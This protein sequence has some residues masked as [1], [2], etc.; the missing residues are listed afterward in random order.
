MAVSFHTV[1]VTPLAQNAT[2]IAEGPGG[3]AVVVDPG[4]D[5]ARIAARLRELK[6]TLKEI[7]L[8]HSHLDHCGGVA[9]LLALQEDGGA[10]IV[11][12][13]HPLERELRERVEEIAAYYG[14]PPGFMKNCP[15]PN[16]PLVGGESLNFAG[17]QFE[18]RFTPGHAPGHLAFYAPGQGLVI[19]GDALFQGSI[20]RTD[21]PGG[22]HQ[23]LIDSI[24]RELLSL[25]DVTRVLC[26]HGSPTTIGA[27]RR[28]N[29][30]LN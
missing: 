17:E 30:F 4:G 26:G 9:D 21:L 6:V 23:Q 5:A 15:E 25:P 10:A 22:N 24:N 16:A 19:G 28:S 12:R 2:I 3:G 18:V 1:V 13:G 27:E 8:T 14:I 20:G 29:P 11:L 7:W